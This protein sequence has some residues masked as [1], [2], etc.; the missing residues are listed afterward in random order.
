MMYSGTGSEEADREIEDRIRSIQISQQSMYRD[1]TT[2]HRASVNLSAMNTS[3]QR[4]PLVTQA[5][6]TKAPP[7]RKESP[8]PVKSRSPP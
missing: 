5:P 6:P 8:K 4:S 3:K 7:T 2:V 1:L